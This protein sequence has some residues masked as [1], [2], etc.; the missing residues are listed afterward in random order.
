MT[1]APA[2]LVD[3]LRWRAAN[4]PGQMAFRFLTDGENEEVLINYAE[5]DRQARLIAARLQSVSKKGER[6]FLLFPPGLDFVTAF[7]GCL[8]AGVI[9]VPVYPP[10]PVR[11]EKSFSIIFSIARDA[12]PTLALLP[13]SLHAALFSG[14]P[15][16]PGWSAIRFIITDEA[17]NDIS[18]E[19]WEAP[20]LSPADTAFLQYTSGSTS[21]PKGVIV[22]HS[23]LLHNLEGIHGSFGL[24]KESHCMVWLPPYHDMGLI[25]GILQPVYSGVP[26]TLMPHMLFLQRPLRWL[27]AISR[28]GVTV[29]G[30]PNFAFDLCIRK[31]K[32]EQREQ[33]D[34]GSWQVAFNGAEPV[35][36]ET[37]ERFAE[38]FAPCGFRKESL[39]PCYGLAEATLLVAGGPRQGVPAAK[40]L[41]NE[42]IVKNKVQLVSG[43]DDDTITVVSCGETISR[44]RI[45]MVNWETGIPCAEDEIGEIW[46]SGPAVA[47]GY[48]NKPA[49]TAIA[50]EARLTGSGEGPFLRTG[51][52]GFIHEGGLYVT[53]R[54]KNLI[55]CEG[56]NHYPHDIERTVEAAHPMIQAGRSAVFSIPKPGSEEVIVLAELEHLPGNRTEEILNAI[57]RA[58]SEYHGVT[59]QDIRLLKP[60][61]IA[62]TTS[63]KIRHFLC[64]ENY[65]AGALN[66]IT[67]V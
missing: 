49:E 66:K 17:V 51:D 1:A 26:V 19:Q 10:H 22:R 20:E 59:V 14:K 52:L 13:G 56:K 34:L 21:I 61:G 6:A 11:P 28:L 58:V 60:G 63:G 65:L 4:Q 9:A 7:F 18:A 8:Y 48:W 25:G 36:A 53:G 62:R 35:S 40:Y 31:I 27:Q 67:V 29:S 39:F 33:L 42:A 55:I 46:F 50:F 24:T 15:I 64:R 3:I 44:H 12:H 45:K 47:G 43:P 54:L 38:Y 5:L 23:N 37:M 16:A 2:T 57:R 30:G 41:L 32:P